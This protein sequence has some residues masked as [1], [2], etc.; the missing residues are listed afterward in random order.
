VSIES[1]Q[2][3]SSGKYHQRAQGETGGKRKKEIRGECF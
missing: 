2:V 3:L 1:G